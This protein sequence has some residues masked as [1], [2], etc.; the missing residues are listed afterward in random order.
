MHIK[1]HGLEEPH[2]RTWTRKL[3]EYL[4]LLSGGQSFPFFFRR[5]D[6][7]GDTQLGRL[8]GPDNAPIL[9]VDGP[10][11]APSEH[12]TNYRTVMLVGAGIGLTPCASVLCALTKYRWKKNFNPEVLYFYWIVRQSEVDGFQWLVHMLTELSYEL[13]KSLQ[14]GQI[15][16]R[17]YCE[18]HIYITGVAKD[19]IKVADLHRAKKVFNASSDDVS[20]SFSADELYRMMCNP[21]VSSKT[22]VAAMKEKDR[23]VTE[24]ST[25]NRLQNIWVWEGR[26]HWDQVFREV[27]DQR[28]HSDIG[29]CFCGAPVIGADLV[30]MCQKYSDIKDKVT[31]ITL[32]LHVTTMTH[33]P[34]HPPSQSYQILSSTH[35]TSYLIC[36]LPSSACLLYTRRTSERRILYNSF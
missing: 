35:L 8:N 20:P 23:S 33:P 18:I 7:R 26:P 2:A 12:Y 16:K 34:I 3:K 32:L 21:E 24:L 27:R 22:Q 19:P 9:R 14:H 36:V 1:V 5:R 10:H 4:E 25:R 15:E 6:A 31:T 30:E 13:K 28:Q 11:Y 17:Y 29:V